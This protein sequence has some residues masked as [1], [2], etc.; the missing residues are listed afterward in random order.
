VNAF[1]DR[2]FNTICKCKEVH[3]IIHASIANLPARL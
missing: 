3:V 1:P 2:L